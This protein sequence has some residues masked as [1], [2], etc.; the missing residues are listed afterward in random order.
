MDY[1]TANLFGR[2]Y[3]QYGILGALLVVAAVL[4][5]L[6]LSQYATVRIEL[7][8]QDAHDRRADITAER[9]RADQAIGRVNEFMERFGS[10][11]V[12]ALTGIRDSMAA[13]KKQLEDLHEDNARRAA[14][15]H[16]KL[17]NMHL[18]VIKARNGG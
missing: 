1:V 16:T 4:V 17:E 8:R 14:N 13:M 12:E 6:R 5:L 9:A 7:M 3:Q 18:D 10:K 2:L 11:T 15:L